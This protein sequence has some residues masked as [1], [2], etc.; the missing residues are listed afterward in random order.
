MAPKIPGMPIDPDCKGL[1]AWVRGGWIS[2]TNKTGSDNFRKFFSKIQR[3]ER[4][5]GYISVPFTFSFS[6]PIL[7]ED[8][9]AIFVDNVNGNYF[10]LEMILCIPRLLFVREKGGGGLESVWNREFILTPRIRPNKTN[11]ASIVSIPDAR[12]PPIFCLK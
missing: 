10:S 7:F 12:Y 2:E 9:R 11:G 8:K 6:V 3:L 1:W 4:N 5:N